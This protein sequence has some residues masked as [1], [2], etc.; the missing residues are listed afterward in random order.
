MLWIQLAGNAVVGPAEASGDGIGKRGISAVW[1][2]IINRRSLFLL[3]YASRHGVS[4]LG[5]TCDELCLDPKCD[6]T[7]RIETKQRWGES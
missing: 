2:V 4:V 3:V 7:F 5:L 1:Q 6:G